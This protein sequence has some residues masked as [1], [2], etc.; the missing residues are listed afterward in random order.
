MERS[1]ADAVW[2]GSLPWYL[3]LAGLAAGSYALAALAVV[4]GDE[5]DRR[6]TRAAFYV[7]FPLLAACAALLILG[8]EP[9]RP[10]RRASSPA[11]R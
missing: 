9:G 10:A 3:F 6:A 7:A 8:G 1:A 4:F 2:Q 11:R 5:S